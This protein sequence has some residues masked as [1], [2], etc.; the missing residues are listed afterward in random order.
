M[1][2]II[3]L[4]VILL[5]VTG[6]YDYQELNNRAIISGISIDYEEKEYIINYEIL[7]NQKSGNNEDQTNKAYLVEGKGP[8]IVE[9]F[10]NASDSISKETYLSHLKV[11]ILSE[12]AAKEKMRDIVDY[13]LREPNI[14]NIFTPVVAKG[15]KAK[16]ILASSTKE[17]PVV[18][19]NINQL[20][21]NNKY[22]EN[23]SIEI[24][25]DKFMD[26]WE[27]ER[28]SPA[29]TSIELIDGLP[30]LGGMALFDQEGLVKIFDKEDTAIFN[31]LNNESSNHHLKLACDN[32]IEGFT[33]INLYKNK[34]TDFEIKEDQITMKSK[35][36]ASVLKDSCGYNFRDSKI[37]E[38]LGNKFSEILKK[39]YETFWEKLKKEKTDILGIQKKYYQK[40]RKELTNWYDLKLDTDIKIEINKNGLTFE[41][42]NNE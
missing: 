17:E 2:K 16:E 26:E 35:L 14:R 8:T 36:N 27:D 31:V 29:I 20:I 9:A 39:E 13:L 12:S 33:I 10:Q 18:S 21:Q 23:V 7:N 6:C 30:S 1:K 25:F 32:D 4:G 38:E 28:K 15:K 37:Y 42:K 3:L 22:S 19:E 34:K 41:V 5:L 24:D 11:L 40:T